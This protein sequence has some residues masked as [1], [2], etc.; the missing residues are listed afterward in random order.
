MSFVPPSQTA[1]HQ[2]LIPAV[3]WIPTWLQSNQNSQELL[4]DVIKVMFFVYLFPVD[5]LE[6]LQ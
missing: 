2:T 3:L 5:P 6:R 4:P 1:G